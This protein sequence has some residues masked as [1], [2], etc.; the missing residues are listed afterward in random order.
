MSAPGKRDDSDTRWERLDLRIKVIGAVVAILAATVAIA[1]GI[2]ELLFDDS[3]GPTTP[4]ITDRVAAGQQLDPAEAAALADPA[5]VAARQINRCMRRHKLP[6]PRVRVGATGTATLYVF[7]RCDWPPLSQPS[8]D[9]YSEIRTQVTTIPG[10]GAADVYNEIDTIRAPCSEL[11]LTFALIHMGERQFKSARL[12]PGRVLG[13]T[14]VEGAD[15]RP[16]ISIA[17]VKNPLQSPAGVDIP[18]P[19]PDRFHVLR[20]GHIDPFDARCF[21]NS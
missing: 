14:T 3:A 2:K 12:L 9:G 17:L 10:K 16:A 4:S 15:R 8:S 20:T 19:F 5:A 7:K 13:V 6:A 11:V 21:R 18:G 1:V